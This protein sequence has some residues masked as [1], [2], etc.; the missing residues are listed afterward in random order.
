M[1]FIRSLTLSAALVGSFAPSA[2]AAG[3]SYQVTGPVLEV[4]DKSIVVQKGKERWELARD[5]STSG[6]ADVKAGDKVTVEYTMT[7]VAVEKKGG[8]KAAAKAAD[9]TTEAAAGPDK[10]AARAPSAVGKPGAPAGA[11]APAT[12]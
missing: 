4:N 5:A 11:G 9:K 8:G 3:K 7:A 1:T 6:A 2:F 12:P 10:A